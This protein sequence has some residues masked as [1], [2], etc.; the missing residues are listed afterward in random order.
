MPEGHCETHVEF[1]ITA[2]HTLE[3]VEIKGL[4]FAAPAPELAYQSFLIGTAERNQIRT[5]K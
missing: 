1:N 5:Q 3:D 4:N 2:A